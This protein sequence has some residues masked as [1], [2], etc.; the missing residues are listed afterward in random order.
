M[1]QCEGYKGIF[2]EARRQ[3]KKCS[4]VLHWDYNEP[5]PTAAGNN[6]ISYPA[7]PKPAYYAVRESCRQQM[8]SARV[9]KFDFT[10]GEKFEAELF[11]LNYLPETIMP[12]TVTA[13]LKSATKIYDL[14]TWHALE[15]SAS[16][17][18]HGCVCSVELDEPDNS[19]LRLTLEV[20]G[21]PDMNSE[22]LFICKNQN[23]SKK[24]LPESLK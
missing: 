3:W 2:E 23:S 17:H 18:Q 4:M 20:A 13:T 12:L 22:Y 1:L 9:K 21:R 8:A 11:I 15:T 14:C 19:L 7:K 16:E 10:S 5:W 6:L 24:I